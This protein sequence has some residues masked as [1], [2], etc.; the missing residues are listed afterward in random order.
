MISTPC[1]TSSS[2][3]GTFSANSIPSILA[4]YLRSFLIL[5]ASLQFFA[6]T[7]EFEAAQGGILFIRVINCLIKS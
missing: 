3:A 1:F 4:Y 6:A 5:A 2:V 7:L